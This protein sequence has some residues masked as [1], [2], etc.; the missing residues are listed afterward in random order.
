VV[1][2]K[3]NLGFAEVLFPNKNGDLLS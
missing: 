1:S 3:M 2:K